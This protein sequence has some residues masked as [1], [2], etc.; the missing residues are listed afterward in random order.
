LYRT[1]FTAGG[2]IEARSSKGGNAGE[3]ILAITNL[4]P[5]RMGVNRILVNPD[6]NQFPGMAHRQGP[7][8][9][10]VNQAENCGVRSNTKGQG[11][12]RHGREG[13]ARPQRSDGVPEILNE[14]V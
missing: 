6:L 12:N 9:Y 2:K 11:E 3:D 5:D 1:G 13:G 7:Q 4:F 14:R 8:D 10:R